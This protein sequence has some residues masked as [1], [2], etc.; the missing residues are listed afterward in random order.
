MMGL[1]RAVRVLPRDAQLLL[2]S[3][4]LGS[5]PIGLLLVFFPLYL[6]DLGLR[7]LLIGGIFTAAG[8]GSSVL[9]LAIGPLADRFGRRAFLITG[10]AIPAL[11]FAPFA[12]TTNVG[13]LV[14]ASMLGGVGFSGGLGGALTTATF[15]PLLAGTVPP[16][17]RTAVMSWSEA[18][19]TSAT[20]RGALLAGVPALI[21]G[22]R[23]APPL[24][25]ARVVFVGCFVLIVG[26]ALVLLPVRDRSVLTI[27]EGPTVTVSPPG[28]P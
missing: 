22:A 18:I 3:S 4:F 16:H 27:S 19:W 17:R 25:A 21:V 26:S 2:L 7:T 1:L 9:L 12:L 24:V 28:R 11:G 20:A 14:V 13:W 6:H 15:N 5:L 23:L 8:V 10:T